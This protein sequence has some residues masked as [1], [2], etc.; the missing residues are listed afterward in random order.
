M[1]YDD[2]VKVLAPCGLN[3]GKCMAYSEGEIKKHSMQLKEL[4]GSFDDYARRFSGFWPVF[5]KYPQFKDVLEYFTRGSCRG[6]RSGDCKYPGCGVA[7][8]FRDKEFGFC[9]QCGEFP[10]EKSNLDENLKARWITMN[11]RMNEIGVEEYYEETKNL[12]RYI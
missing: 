1:K 9:F 3:C 7:A 6:C 8:C 5:E 12:P 2:I 11:M 10:C 4:L